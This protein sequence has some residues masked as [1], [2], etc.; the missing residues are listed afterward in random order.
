MWLSDREREELL[1]AMR[2]WQGHREELAAVSHMNRNCDELSLAEIDAVCERL[3]ESAACRC[4]CDQVVCAKCGE[5]E[6]G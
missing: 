1:C 3:N 6:E 4:G 5:T 2:H